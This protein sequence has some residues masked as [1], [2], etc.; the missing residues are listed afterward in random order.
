MPSFSEISASEME[1]HCSVQYVTW[2]QY[3]HTNLIAA[4][5]TSTVNYILN[6]VTYYDY[7]MIL[8][9]GDTSSNKLSIVFAYTVDAMGYGW[10]WEQFFDQIEPIATK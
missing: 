10:R 5:A 6:D 1:V 3:R 7:D 2:T 4:A 9:I 8:H